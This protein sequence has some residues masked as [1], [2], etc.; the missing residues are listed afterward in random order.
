MRWLAVLMALASPALAEGERA[1]DF[2]YFVLALSWQP[3][4]CAREGDA[5]DA[6]TCAPEADAGWTVHGLWPQYET[7]WPSYCDTGMRDPTR[8]ETAAEADIFGSAGSAWYQWKK[9]GRCAGLPPED[10]FATVRRAYEG[11][12]RPDVFRRLQ[13]AVRLPARVVEEAF[14]EANPDLAPDMLTITCTSGQIQ[15]ARLCLTQGL[16]PRT[17]GADVVRDCSD[18]GALLYPV[19]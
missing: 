10:Y 9:H 8:D 3:N 18:S 11:V 1:G 7:G 16:E 13:E 12:T 17:C 14:L 5:R 19:R 2:D 6:P 15:E 4:W